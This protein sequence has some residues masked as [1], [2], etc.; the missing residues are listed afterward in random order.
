MKTDGWIWMDGHNDINNI[1]GW[2]EI[3]CMTFIIGN[4]FTSSQ[5]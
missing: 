2:T 1:N 5:N 4:T 3:Y